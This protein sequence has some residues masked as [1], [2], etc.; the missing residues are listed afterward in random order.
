[1]LMEN[2]NIHNNKYKNGKIYKIIDLAYTE[3]YFGSTIQALCSRMA[4]HRSDYKK[5]L[6]GGITRCSSFILFD[7]YTPQ[8]CKIELVEDFPCSSKS[9]LLKREGYYIQNHDC[10]NKQVAG[11]SHGEYME[12]NKERIAA[13][14]KNFRE[15]NAER[16]K[17]QRKIC[18]E[19]RRDEILQR[20]RENRQLNPEKFREYDK[21][22]YEKHK[23]V[24]LGRNKAYRDLNIDRLRDDKRE[25][26]HQHKDMILQRQLQPICC[27]VCNTYIVRANMSRHQKSKYCQ[28]FKNNNSR[29]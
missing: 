24:I 2:T 9:E 17:E 28:E 12:D 21:N 13:R 23:D 6:N 20:R 29:N 19:R 27:P 16:I 26:Y 25:Y 5:R 8:G 18:F 4:L 7:K 10:V 1:M 3:Q 15:M 22:R 11:R 14:R